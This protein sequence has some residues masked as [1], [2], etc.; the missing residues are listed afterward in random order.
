MGVCVTSA[1]RPREWH[2]G[3]Q[4]SCALAATGPV[5][6]GGTQGVYGLRR[7]RGKGSSAAP[8]VAAVFGVAL[9]SKRGSA[10]ARAL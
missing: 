6:H 1:K 9:I 10:H 2:V 7:S 4:D 3:P 8:V 5:E